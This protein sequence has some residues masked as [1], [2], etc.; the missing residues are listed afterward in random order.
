MTRRTKS[1]DTDPGAH[2]RAPQLPRFV[3]DEEVGLG[4]VIK[5]V[6]HTIGIRACGGCERRA[7]TLNRWLRFNYRAR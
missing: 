6:T 4:D 2:E 1:H 7:A 3:T 5:R